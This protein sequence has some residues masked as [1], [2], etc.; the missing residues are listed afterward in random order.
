MIHNGVSAFIF[1]SFAQF[2]FGLVAVVAIDDDN[3]DDD[4]VFFIAI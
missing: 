2:L 4:D 1:F 3:N